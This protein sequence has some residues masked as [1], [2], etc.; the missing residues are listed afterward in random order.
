MQRIDH[1]ELHVGLVVYYKYENTES[2]PSGPFRVAKFFA[3]HAGKQVV[4]TKHNP[5]DDV[6]VKLASDDDYGEPIFYKPT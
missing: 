3:N 6:I 4:L 1:D 2:P 5:T